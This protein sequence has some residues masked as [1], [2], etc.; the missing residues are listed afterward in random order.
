MLASGLITKAAI[1]E[2]ETQI[3]A[4]VTESVRF[5]EESPY[6]EPEEAMEDLFA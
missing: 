2:M 6:P 3:G 4:I 1:E 5:A